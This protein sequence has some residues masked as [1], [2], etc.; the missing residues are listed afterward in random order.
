M[1]HHGNARGNQGGNH[2][3]LLDA[4]FEFDRLTT[5]FLEDA[6]GVFNRLVDA[7]RWK[8]GKGHSRRRPRP[9]HRPPN[10]FG[11][12][13]HFL[14][15]D[16]EGVRMA[17][18]DH[19]KGVADQNSLRRRAASTNLGRWESRRPSDMAISARRPSSP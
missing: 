3:G 17:L 2:L 16:R 15:G 5:G 14:Q 13:D 9:A 12:V 11:M 19:G 1:P 4:T 18:D 10:H 6:A 8:L 7:L